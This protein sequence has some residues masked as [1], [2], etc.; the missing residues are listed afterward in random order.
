MANLVVARKLVGKIN[1]SYFARPQNLIVQLASAAPTPKTI[2][3]VPAFASFVLDGGPGK[4]VHPQQLSAS[5]NRTTIAE[6][7]KRLR[8]RHS[9]EGLPNDPGTTRQLNLEPEEGSGL[10]RFATILPL[11]PAVKRRA[12]ANT[13]PRA[14]PPPKL[15]A[16]LDILTADIPIV[17]ALPLLLRTHLPGARCVH[18]I[19]GMGEGAYRWN[20][21]SGFGRAEECGVPVG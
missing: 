17:V 1:I 12:S 16:D 9:H 4:V 11:R 6:G 19:L 3:F 7:L 8:R 10:L 14:A 5:R 18:M 13:S 15:E 20:C 2:L 21:L